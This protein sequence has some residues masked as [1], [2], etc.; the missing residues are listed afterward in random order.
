M[1][2][3][4]CAAGYLYEDAVENP[5]DK[6]DASGLVHYTDAAFWD[7][8]AG[9]FHERTAD[10]L[11]VDFREETGEDGEKEYVDREMQAL[12]GG[13]W[14]EER[15]RQEVKE[16]R[17]QEAF[18]R[19]V[20][21]GVAG[22]MM[23]QWGGREGEG[24]GMASSSSAASSLQETNRR[25]E[26]RGP[27]ARKGSLYTLSEKEWEEIDESGGAGRGQPSLCVSRQRDRP[28]ELASTGRR[29]KGGEESL[30]ER[31]VETGASSSGLPTS[32]VFKSVLL[33]QKVETGR[34]G[35]GYGR[36]LSLDETTKKASEE[37][38]A[39]AAPP[40]PGART[41][42]GG[43]AG[44]PLLLKGAVRA[45]RRPAV[46]PDLL[47]NG[48]SD[49]ESNER[50]EK[51]AKR[52]GLQRQRE[53]RDGFRLRGREERAHIPQLGRGLPTHQ[54][55]IG[56]QIDSDQQGRAGVRET[57]PVSEMDPAFMASFQI[58]DQKC[59]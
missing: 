59:L 53:R 56:M 39:N 28:K 37:A 23:K 1:N 33:Q 42:L 5:W 17:S 27:D 44:L 45:A 31:Q 24:L 29:S 51:A 13:Q 35:I 10:D 16:R 49:E 58:E 25:E 2:R 30:Q 11:D 18:E 26:G 55:V 6:H 54:K 14:G 8:M 52:D 15:L 40:A 19:F 36:G 3:E 12:W 4:G 41:R 38:A 48:G 9:D 43:T 34:H 21:G 7:Q 50:Q 57:N 46:P 20:A 32:S 22:R 47:E